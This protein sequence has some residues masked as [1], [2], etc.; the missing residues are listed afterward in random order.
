MRRYGISHHVYIYI[1]TSK[2]SQ[3][4]SAFI[5]VFTLTPSEAIRIRSVAQPDYASN[6]VGVATRMINVSF[7]FILQLIRLL[8]RRT[9]PTQKEC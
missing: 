7:V 5:G 8:N 6:A 4:T 3:A 9:C 2:N 1:Y